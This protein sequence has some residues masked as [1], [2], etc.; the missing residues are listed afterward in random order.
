MKNSFFPALVSPLLYSYKN[1]VLSFTLAFFFMVILQASS[2]KKGGKCEEALNVNQ[3]SI[4]VI[5][6]DQNSGKYLY[7]EVN[8]LYNKDSL[9]IFDPLGNSLVLLTSLSTIPGTS[10]RY[11]RINFG[12]VYNQQTD[13]NSFDIEICKYFVVKYSYNESDTIKTCFKSIKTECGSVFETLKVFNKDLLL[14]TVNNETF[15]EITIQK[16]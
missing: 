13:A 8:P 7:S 11:W 10:S 2:C 16:N 15:T 14:V 4:E 3:S 5:F 6:K 9:K 1:N 12:N